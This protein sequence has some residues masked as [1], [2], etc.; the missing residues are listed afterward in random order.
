MTSTRYKEAYEK[1]FAKLSPGVQKKVLEEKT[2]SELHD[3][4]VRAFV[5]EVIQVAE[6]EEVA[7]PAAKKQ[8]VE[9]PVDNPS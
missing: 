1:L 7:K 5:R 2:N 3:P 8:R 9:G 6:T 4:E